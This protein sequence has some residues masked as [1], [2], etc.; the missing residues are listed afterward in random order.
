MSDK[1]H[2]LPDR[3][4]ALVY[5]RLER[6]M[7]SRS[8][9]SQSPRAVVIG[10]QPGAGKSMLLRA[11]LE[12]LSGAPA[13]IL[14]DDCRAAHPLSEEILAS[15]E[16]HYA[17]KTDLDVK[18]WMKRLLM[19]AA[20]NRRDIVFEGDKRNGDLLVNAVNR[21]KDEGYRVDVL[22]MAVG[23]E[24]SRLGILERYEEQ[25][26]DVG[27]GLWVSLESHNKTYNNIPETVKTAELKCRMDSFGVCNRAG[28]VLYRNVAREGI[29]TKPLHNADARAA[30]M[31]ERG[32]PLSK[33]EQRSIDE[34]RMRVL[35]KMQ[36]RGASSGEIAHAMMMLG[37]VHRLRKELE[38]REAVSDAG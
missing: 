19:V 26:E 17:D 28:K 2:K 30:I 34:G 9:E 6:D 38:A 21:L 27:Y 10:G 35:E 25:R 20:G 7:L 8:A 32:R 24:V 11:A 3:E 13:V 5:R 16:K 33:E 23:G 37:N 12:S 15:D 18:I 4:H 14:E 36:R 31:K 1:R 22:V 29:Y